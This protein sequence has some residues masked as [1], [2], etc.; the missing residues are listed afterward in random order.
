MT[1]STIVLTRNIGSVAASHL[2]QKPGIMASNECDS[3]ADT[4]CFGKN[5]VILE[6]NQISEDVYA[7]NQ[8]IKPIEG[9]PTINDKMAWD[10]PE[11]NQTC[12]LVI[13]EAL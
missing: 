3:N 7:Y 1:I 9:V 4:C 8:S 10:N 13:K 11:S 12:I 5:L 6:Y 2:E